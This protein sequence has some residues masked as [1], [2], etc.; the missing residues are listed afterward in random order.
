MRAV[1]VVAFMLLTVG[2]AAADKPSPEL[3]K[4]VVERWK[5][6]RASSQTGYREAIP[7]ELSAQVQKKRLARNDRPLTVGERLPAVAGLPAARPLAIVFFRG[8]W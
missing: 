5:K 8:H 1:S 6:V 2:A 3:V 7:D 4:Q